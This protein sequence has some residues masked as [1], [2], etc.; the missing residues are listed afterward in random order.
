MSHL[1]IHFVGYQ[2]GPRVGLVV[3]VS[4]WKTEPE[5][6]RAFPGTNCKAGFVHLACQSDE[7]S[8]DCADVGKMIPLAL[9]CKKIMAV[10][11][12]MSTRKMC[13]ITK[14][15]NFVG[16][17]HNFTSFTGRGEVKTHWH[18]FLNMSGFAHRL[19][20]LILVLGDKLAS[21]HVADQEAF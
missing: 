15:A 18:I 6:S 11:L 1:P 7:L 19:V 14:Y 4:S 8:E 20:I 17:E 10:G 12:L 13:N 2:N 3:A 16:V 9:R 5:Q 21:V